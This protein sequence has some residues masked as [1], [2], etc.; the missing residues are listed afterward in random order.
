MGHFPLLCLTTRGYT[1]IMMSGDGMIDVEESR[2]EKHP[3]WAQLGPA[4]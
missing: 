3:N 2:A 4:A 1:Y